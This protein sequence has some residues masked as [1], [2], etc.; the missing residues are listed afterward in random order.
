MWADTAPVTRHVVEVMGTVFSLDV[1]D[2]DLPPGVLAAVE[3]DLR[4]VDATFSTYRADSDV[5]RLAAGA[6][7]LDACAPEVAEVL[8][9]C[10]SYGRAT[11]GY[12][13]A[14]PGGRLDPSGLVKGWA[15]AR[16]S[17]LLTAAGLR[18]HAVNG[19]GD[20]QTVGSPAPGAHWRV[21][22]AD[23]LHPGGLAVVVAGSDIAVA[24]SGV[25]ERGHHIVDPYT[26][27]PA[28]DVAS[29]TVVGPD[30]VAADVYATAAVAMGA[31][32]RDWLLRLPGHAA[33]VVWADGTRWATPGFAR[34]AA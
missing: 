30:I 29:A 17:R 10:A 6:V 26:G 7:R 3:A 13:T 24:T 11:D 8:D 31:A 27:R 5:S 25:A 14:T 1:R 33:F 28:T 22:V 23:P 19:G 32:A 9:L 16:A 18:P 34:Y 21:G 4:W 12:F 15:V 2:G 20:V